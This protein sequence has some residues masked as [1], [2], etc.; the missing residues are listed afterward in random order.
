MK[1]KATHIPGLMVV[2]PTLIKDERGA[3][4][5]VFKASQYSRSGIKHA[6]EQENRSISR[7]NVLRG[8]HYQVAPYAQAK[9][10]GCIAGRLFDVAVDIRPGSPTYGKHFSI[11]LNPFDGEMLY[12]PEG[13]AHGFYSMDNDTVMS[14][15]CSKEYSPKHERGFIFDDIDVGIK[16][17]A[18]YPIVSAKDAL[19]PAFKEST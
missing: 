5:E 1:F 16:W 11:E 14:Y 3:F 19:L 17:P 2:L 7:Q 15:R 4:M 18:E 10:V 12:I 8:M 13:F 9:L 6:W